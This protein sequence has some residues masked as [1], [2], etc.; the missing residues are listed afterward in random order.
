MS[1]EKKELSQTDIRR[2]KMMEEMKAAYDALPYPVLYGE[3]D[4]EVT[5]M[6][7]PAG[8][9]VGL[10]TWFT[11]PK[12]KQAWP[13][14]VQRSCYAD[15]IE[16][17]RA[18]ALEYAKRGF[19]YVFQM[20][21]GTGGSEGVWE[22]NVN[23]RA[24]GLSLLQY[25]EARDDVL[26]MG[27]QGGSYLA[28]TGWIMAD[29]VPEKLKTMYLTVYGTNRH[30][31]AYKDG[32][33]RQDILTA[34]AM[35]NAGRKVEADYLESAAYRPQ[36][37]VDEALWGG[38][39]QWYR[40]WITN[41]SRTDEYWKEGLWKQLREIPE[42]VTYPVFIVEGWYDHHLGSALHGYTAL[43]PEAVG[44]ST[45]EIGP[46]NHSF[47]PAIYGHPDQQNGWSRQVPEMFAWFYEILVE[48]KTPERKIRWYVIGADKWIEL[49]EYPVPVE[50][51]K[52]LYLGE[53]GT[54]LPEPGEPAERSYTYD[55]E[56]PVRSH[57]AE[58]LFASQQEV[59]S[60]LQ[61]GPDSR[62]DIISFVSEPLT[63]DLTILG[64]PAVE[65][66]V[67]SDAEDTC[68]TV[69]LMEVFE[70]GEA[71]NIRNGITTLAYR[72]DSPDRITYT[73][74]ELV[75]IRIETWDVAWM[76]KKGSRL[77]VDVSSSNFPEYAVHPNKAGVWSVIRETVPAVETVCYG[78]KTPSAVILPVRA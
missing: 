10:R 77:R 29:A 44:T 4:I 33:F 66:Y 60:R 58:S 43:N 30:T 59:G 57:G 21:R 42:K 31:S 63:E 52:R 5:E 62:P 48:G 39:L 67:R 13:T 18:T 6:M 45:L 71:Y 73:P 8:D 68:F 14:I 70:N 47:Q 12:E 11:K 28:F 27:Y 65:L 40:D 15:N 75:K 22:P 26:V 17:G 35:G 76:L 19:A 72:N 24:D 32:L 50:A 3:E 16:I 7:L 54:L 51:E 20:C 56:D 55:P 1:E 37:E 9:G 25:L 64:K 78:G 23:D 2:A 46:W 38:K 36:V 41:T 69:K 49:P 61:P 34:W 74:N 53:G